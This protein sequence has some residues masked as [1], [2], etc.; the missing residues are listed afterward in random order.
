MPKLTVPTIGRFRVIRPLGQGGMG[1]VYLADDPLLNRTV[2]IKLLAA[3]DMDD[4]ERRAFFRREATSAAALN[5]PNICTIFEVGDAEGRPYIAMEAIEGS[6]L[7]ELIQQGLLSVDEVIAVALQVAHA[8]EEAQAQ[9]VVHRDLKSA[10]IMV[11][12]KGLV[13]VLDFGLAKQMDSEPIDSPKTTRWVSRADVA[14]GTLPYMSPE[15]ALGRSV[16]HR[17]DLFSFGTILYEALT[18]TVPFD[19]PTAAEVLNAVVNHEPTP[20]ASR[21]E[22]VPPALARVVARLL[23]KA[24]ADRYQTASAVAADLREIQRTGDVTDHHPRLA[25]MKFRRS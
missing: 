3:D 23:A 7:T 24:P 2:A 14:L 25:P 16:D 18:G 17:S 12:P 21:N 19:G 13:K 10:N 5:H 11:T 20:I 6:T 4:P 9:Q 15:Q 1:E 8:L 22:K